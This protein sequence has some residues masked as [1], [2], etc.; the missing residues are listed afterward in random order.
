MT[1]WRCTRCPYDTEQPEHVTAISHRCKPSIPRS[2]PLQPDPTTQP[3]ES[4]GKRN[5]T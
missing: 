3:T 4:K 5:A 1:V 2:Y